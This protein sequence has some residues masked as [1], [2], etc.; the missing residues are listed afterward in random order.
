LPNSNDEATDIKVVN[1]SLFI[2][3]Q[4]GIWI[5][6]LQEGNWK[7][8]QVDETIVKFIKKGDKLFGITH[9]GAAIYSINTE[10]EGKP[11]KVFDSGEFIVWDVDIMGD[12][13]GSRQ[14]QIIPGKKCRFRKDNKNF[15]SISLKKCIVKN[16]S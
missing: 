6:N 15:K 5:G 11:E 8:T 16:F 1:N 3:T 10:N 9:R 14:Y 4:N 12:W 13:Y 2:T 7:K